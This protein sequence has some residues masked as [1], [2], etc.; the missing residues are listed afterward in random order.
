MERDLRAEIMARLAKPAAS[1]PYCEVASRLARQAVRLPTRSD[2]EIEAPARKR[3][4]KPSLGTLIGQ[5]E[6]AGKRVTSVTRDG[7]TLTF[8]DQT[9]N[10]AD[11]WERA[12]LTWG[13]DHGWTMHELAAMSGHTSLSMLQHYTKAADQRRTARAALTRTLGESKTETKV[14]HPL[15]HVTKRG[16]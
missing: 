3:Q 2:D 10:E 1:I 14:S 4:R 12:G 9:N 13:A 16:G 6:K 8:T 11:P 7:V 15:T 5:A